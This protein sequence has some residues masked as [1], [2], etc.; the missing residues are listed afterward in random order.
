MTQLASG[1]QPSLLTKQVIRDGLSYLFWGR[2]RVKSGHLPP[3]PHAVPS[4][5]VGVC[6]ASNQD[7]AT[8]DY[9]VAQVQAL[10]LKRVRLDFSYADLNNYNQRFLTRLLAEG[11]EVTLHLLQ[12]FE[13]AKHMHLPEHQQAWRDFLLAVLDTFGKQVSAIEIGNTVNRKRWCGYTWQGFMQAWAIAHPLIKARGITLVGPNV[14]DFEP[15]YNISILKALKAKQQLPDVHS[16]NLFVERAIEPERF[17]HR[18]FKYQWA[19]WFK[20]NLV[21]KARI[22]QK[23]GHDFGVKST[24]SSAVFWAIYRIQR[25]LPD[26]QQKQADYAAR[27]FILLAASGAVSHANWG[28]LICQR[29]GLISDGLTEADYPD[30]ERVAQYAQA[31][32]ALTDYQHHASF[33][34]VKTVAAM[35]QGAEYIKPIASAQGL[36]IHLFKNG[37]G[38]FHAAWSING[39]AYYL[40]DVYSASDLARAQILHRDGE[41]LKQAPLVTES[42]MYLL[43]GHSPPEM[44]SPAAKPIKLHAHVQGQ[45]YFAFKQD[46]WQGLLLA[47]NAEQAQTMLTSLHPALLKAPSKEGALRHAR[48][49]IWSV[50][51]PRHVDTKQNLTVKQPV[52]MYP[53]KAFLDRFKPSK[54]QRSWDGAM[55]LLR[56]GIATAMPV[57]YFEK[58]G[59]TTLKQNFYLC[60]FVESDFTIGQ[61]FVAFANGEATFHGLTA[62][63]IY[64]QFAHFCHTM[65]A[66]GI[67]F[68][69][70]SGGNI[71]VKIGPNQALSFSLIDTARLHSFDLGAPFNLRI[72]DLTRA[73]NKLHWAGRIRFMQI[74]LGLNGRQLSWRYQW[75]FYVYDFKVAL[76]R[77]IG[78]KGIKR[79]VKRIK[80]Q[81]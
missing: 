35:L 72:A 11:F 2:M 9:V 16:D 8:D 75:P 60:E 59:D 57:A 25:F 53:H 77:K 42:P 10:G 61:A 64:Q 24:V 14:Q 32:G 73:L 49:A 26:G 12:P 45:T 34:A 71:L 48:N 52:K 27:Y 38:Y 15:F 4:D 50:A 51:D 62:E 44:S 41:L 63:Q 28:A 17:D 29:E 55:E 21:K 68:R 69:D 30:L 56:R 81:A 70:F 22:L 74:Y 58:V 5:F 6:V 1:K 78:R 40:D 36:E 80:G 13:S 79:L 18:I 66:R 76:K 54:A 39:H 20:Y 46:G 7:P 65:H 19:K 67:Y 43:W 37:Q 33:K 31:D 3:Y 23:I 47:K